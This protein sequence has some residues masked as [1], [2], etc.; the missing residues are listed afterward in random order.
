MKFKLSAKT[1]SKINT[2]NLTDTTL[3]NWAR[4]LYPAETPNSDI[5]KCTYSRS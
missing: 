4:C 1:Q 3:G 5:Y 2:G